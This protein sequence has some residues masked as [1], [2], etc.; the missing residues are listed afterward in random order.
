MAAAVP[1]PDLHDAAVRHLRRRRRPDLPGD[2]AGG[3]GRHDLAAAGWPQ[4]AVRRDDAGLRRSLRP[5]GRPRPAA[6]TWPATTTS[7][8]PA[9]RW[10]TAAAADAALHVGGRRRRLAP[11][12]RHA[13]P[14]RRARAR[15]RRLHRPAGRAGH[16]Q[17]LRT[18]T[19]PSSPRSPTAT[20]WS[21]PTPTSTPRSS[22][23]PGC[24]G[25]RSRSCR[26]PTSPPSA[27]ARG[28]RRPARAG[29]G[30]VDLLRARRRGDRCVELAEV[31]AEHGALLVVD[32]A[33]GARRARARRRAPAR[34]GRPRRTSSSPLTLS[35]ALGSQ[36]G[37]VL[38]SAASSSTTWSTRPGRSSST[39][40]WRR[41]PPA[42]RWPRSACCATG[43]SCPA[44]CAPGRRPGRQ[45]GVEPPAGAVVSLPMPSPQAARGR[46]G[47][48]AARRG[49]WSAASGRRR[50]PT[51]SRGCGSR[52]APAS[53]TTT[54]RA[55]SRC[56]SGWPRTTREV[57]RRHRHLDRRRQ[58]RRDG[59]AR[60]R[61]TPA[62][63]VVVKPVQTG[64][65]DG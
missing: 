20:A 8:C 12:D 42:P 36:G 63:V 4:Q 30:R 39:P 46:A 65:A 54:G 44:S 1:R 11:G 49:C 25:P 56:S 14:A 5:R 29:A 16:W 6:S 50:C 24:R 31:C 32:E 10:S 62:P 64:A 15:A 51:A 26:T 59:G 22:T 47:R 2:R 43:P 60:R 38:G 23:R 7:G 45:L 61:S 17:R 19:S 33:H 52:S 34:A 57:R 13:R 48:G 41:P 35:K 55:P 53:P 27:R 21:S 40:R 3:D 9:T 37:A 58:D 18:P 28:R